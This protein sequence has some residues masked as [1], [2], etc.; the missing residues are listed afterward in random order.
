MNMLSKTIFFM[1]C[2]RPHRLALMKP[3]ACVS[4][5]CF[6]SELPPMMNFDTKQKKVNAKTLCDIT[7]TKYY[8]HN[9]EISFHADKK[10]RVYDEND[11]LLGDLSFAEAIESSKSAKKDL[12]LRQEKA[13][14]PVCKIMNYKMELLKKL[15]K[16]LGRQ[17][18]DAQDEAKMKTLRM[19]TTIAMHD[20][21][22]KKRKTL[23]Y[24]KAHTGVRIMM[25]VNVYDEENIEKGRLML[26]NIADELKEYCKVK[27]APTKPMAKEQKEEEKA[28]KPEKGR[29][30]KDG[31]E[32]RKDGK[33]PSKFEDIKKQADLQR[34]QKDEILNVDDD[35]DDD[36]IEGKSNFL[37]MELQ[38]TVAFKEID[39]DTMLKH[40]TLDDLMRGLYL[41][42]ISSETPT[43]KHKTAQERLMDEVANIEAKKAEET[44][45]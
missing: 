42:A 44:S 9:E 30:G 8:M 20:L 6:A 2:L 38:S 35:L 45:E 3:V 7:G 40:T 37:T 17:G 13:D 28:K 24:L 11:Q 18:E 31:K 33:K 12:V 23:E 34:R 29:K 43:S 25:R 5:R 1:R 32:M 26:L 39:I 19:S 14:P 15:F 27:V 41:K 22:N 10:V 21:E 36:D 16:K 4:R